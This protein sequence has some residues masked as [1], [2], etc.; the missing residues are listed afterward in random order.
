MKCMSTTLRSLCVLTPL[1]LAVTGIESRYL[2]DWWLENLV[3]GALLLALALA[4]KR[5]PLSNFSYLMLFA[6]LCAH[7]YGALYSY[8]DT[9]AGDW[10]KV[11]LHSDRN[12]FDRL[13]HL[14]F[15][16]MLT[17][18][19]YEMWNT[20]VRPQGWLVYVLPIQ[21]IVTASAIYEVLEWVVASVVD[22]AS[23]AEFIGAQGDEWDSPKDMALAALGSLAAMAIIGTVRLVRAGR[24]R[25]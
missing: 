22:P 14:L 21:S 13:I 17:V 2:K 7:E 19:V 4:H 8:S 16:L 12:D 3:V 15:G 24:R 10:M 20:V 18:P 23:G 25:G 5:L 9:P 1:V 11:W 6:F